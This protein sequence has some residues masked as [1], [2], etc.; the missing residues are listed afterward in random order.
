MATMP[1]TRPVAAV[2][3]RS[4]RDLSLPRQVLLQALCVL[5]AVVLT[6]PIHFAWIG[7]DLARIGR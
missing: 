6:L 5:L 2:R 7:I 1:A 4:R 3:R